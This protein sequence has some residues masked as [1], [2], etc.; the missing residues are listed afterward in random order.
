[1][2]YKKAKI[3]EYTNKTVCNA[4]KRDKLRKKQLEKITKKKQSS[5]LFTQPTP[6]MLHQIKTEKG[7]I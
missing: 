5:Y 4:P 7:K 3:L 6:S 2:K 1:M